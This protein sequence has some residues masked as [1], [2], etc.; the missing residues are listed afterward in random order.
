MAAAQHYAD[1]QNANAILE[2]RLDKIAVVVSDQLFEIGE[3]REKNHKT[4]SGGQV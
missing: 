1:L 4:E 3:L 2:D